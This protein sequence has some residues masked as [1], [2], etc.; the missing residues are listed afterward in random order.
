MIVLKIALAECINGI[1][2]QEF[3]IHKCNNIKELRQLIEESINTYNN[4]R[5]H[6]SLNMKIPNFAHN[7]KPEE[8]TSLV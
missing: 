1:L 6:L 3:L 2:K 5:S 8:L 4:K 7:K